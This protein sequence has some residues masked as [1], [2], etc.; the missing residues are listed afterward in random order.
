MLEEDLKKIIKSYQDF[1]TQGIL[2]RDLLPILQNP[3]LF[4]KLINSMASKEIFKEARCIL[5]IDARGFL[6]GSAISLQLSKP[7][8][9]ARKPGKLPGKIITHKYELEYGS[10]SLSIQDDSI[11]DFD[12]FVIVDDLLATGGTVNC[13]TRILESCEKEVLGILVVV[14]LLKLKGKSRLNYPVESQIKFEN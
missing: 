9:L 1:P 3:I 8:I 2:F 7:L 13:V 6:F 14:E 4:R 12:N 5:A 10:N 11:R